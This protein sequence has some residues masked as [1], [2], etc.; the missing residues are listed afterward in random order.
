MKKLIIIFLFLI[1]L[2]LTGLTAQTMFVKETNET[3]TEYILSDVKMMKFS[4]GN[5]TISKTDGNSDTYA[6]SGL[7]YL[8]FIDISTG[9]VP[10]ASK[11]EVMKLQVYPNPVADVLSINIQFPKYENQTGVIEILSIEGK[12]FYTQM[13]N[14]QA[15]IYQVN[16]TSFPKGL[17]LCKINNGKTIETLKFLKQ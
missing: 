14:S 1:V 15:N 7:S 16:V 3:Q 4:S 10:V 11:T 6:L 17:Y 2:G 12:I 8:N 13:I 9:I 5:I